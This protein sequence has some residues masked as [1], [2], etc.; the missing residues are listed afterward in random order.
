MSVGGREAAILVSDNNA[1]RGNGV[2]QAAFF[3]ID[4]TLLSNKTGHVIPQGTKDALVALRRR[5]V[6]CCICSG[7]PKAQ[8]PWC[9]R[10][11]S[12]L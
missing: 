7:R 1:R 6:K 3:D 8:L 12:R 10:R 2:I 9:I 11:L 4:G 5:G